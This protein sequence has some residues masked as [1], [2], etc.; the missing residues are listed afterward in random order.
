[1]AAPEALQQ[2]D[3]WPAIL[4]AAAAAVAAVLVPLNGFVKTLLDYRTEAKKAEA[5]KPEVARD[6]AQACTGAA[7]F[8]SMAL[9][10]LTKAVNGLTAAIVADTASEEAYHT[11]QMTAALARFTEVMDRFDHTNGQPRPRR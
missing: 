9:A 6:V 5:L 4:G 7:L 2:L 8:D 11:S 1:M 3:S 10:D